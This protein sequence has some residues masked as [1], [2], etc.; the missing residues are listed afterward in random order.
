MKFSDITRTH[1]HAQDKI[2]EVVKHLWVLP[3]IR[4][5]PWA[6]GYLLCPMR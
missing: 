6:S 3:Q 4:E 2:R 1:T 5:V